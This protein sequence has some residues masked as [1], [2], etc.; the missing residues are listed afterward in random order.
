[1]ATVRA[2]NNETGEYQHIPEHWLNLENEAFS[3]FTKEP[4]KGKATPAT[5]KVQVTEPAEPE[6]AEDS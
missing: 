3:K 1:M 4:R 6:K 2:Y 5:K